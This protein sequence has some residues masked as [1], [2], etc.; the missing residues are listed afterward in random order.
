MLKWRVLSLCAPSVRRY[1]GSVS[2]MYKTPPSLWLILTMGAGVFFVW[3]LVCE[4][5]K[6]L[7]LNLAMSGGGY[8]CFGG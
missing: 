7:E 2:K 6:Y 4:K 3:G 5:S 1:D 8:F